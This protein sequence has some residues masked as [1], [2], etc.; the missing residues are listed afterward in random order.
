MIA[1]QMCGMYVKPRSCC[2]Y[3][4]VSGIFLPPMRRFASHSLPRHSNQT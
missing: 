2:P 4:A 1:Q 3:S